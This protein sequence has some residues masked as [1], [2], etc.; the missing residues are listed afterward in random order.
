VS[1]RV[2]PGRRARRL[3]FVLISLLPA[4]C[5]GGGGG[6]ST[7]PT[8]TAQVGGNWSLTETLTSATGGDCVGSVA[9][10][11]IGAS[12]PSEFQLGQ[13]GA[14]LTALYNDGDIVCTLSGTAAAESFTLNASAC[15]VSDVAVRCANGQTREVRYGSFRVNA[16]VIDSNRFTG[17]STQ[18]W[19]VTTTTGEALPPM[20]LVV[21]VTGIKR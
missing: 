2:N 16:T 14:D 21:T 8:R 11:A 3:A 5:G 1:N 13:T 17:V 12:F 20:V 15:Q 10:Q 6:T 4:A 19:N 9:A 18:T 7:S